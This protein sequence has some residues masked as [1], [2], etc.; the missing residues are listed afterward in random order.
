MFNEMAEALVV[1][2]GRFPLE[3]INKCL[4]NSTYTEIFYRKLMAGQM[5]EPPLLPPSSQG[6]QN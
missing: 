3:E 2:R 1:V 5:E 4:S 6:L